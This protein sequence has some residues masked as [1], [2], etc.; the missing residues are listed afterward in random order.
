MTLVIVFGFCAA[1]FFYMKEWA[2]SYLTKEYNFGSPA[3]AE[4]IPHS[5]TFS[6][7]V[8]T[9]WGFLLLGGVFWGFTNIRYPGKLT[10]H[11]DRIEMVLL[12][13]LSLAIGL[14]YSVIYRLGEIRGVAQMK[15]THLFITGMQ[16]EH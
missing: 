12:L 1:Y 13:L 4:T 11:G 3:P 8:A 16:K 15:N 7:I 9:I 2:D 10:V 5:E 14:S 6:V